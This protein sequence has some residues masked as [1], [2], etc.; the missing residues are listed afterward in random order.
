MNAAASTS[1]PPFQTFW[2][3]YTFDLNLAWINSISTKLLNLFA[4]ELNPAR[5]ATFAPARGFVLSSVPLL[6]NEEDIVLLGRGV[7]QEQP[8]QLS[9]YRLSDI[10]HPDIH[11]L[12]HSSTPT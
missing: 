6:D 5:L 9:F 10:H 4:S 8:D 1:S 2:L 11:H 12:R 3:F 7:L